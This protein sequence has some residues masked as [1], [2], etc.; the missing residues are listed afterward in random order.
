[1]ISMA[2][3]YFASI[4]WPSG[5]LTLYRKYGFFPPEEAV[6][7]VFPP[8]E[9][10]KL[11]FFRRAEEELA[12]CL[13]T[14]AAEESED[15][16]AVTLFTAAGAGAEEELAT[17]LFAALGEDAAPTVV[18]PVEGDAS[19]FLAPVGAGGK[20]KFSSRTSC[21]P[22]WVSRRGSRNVKAPAD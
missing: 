19:S 5:L 17:T 12:L 15:E 4:T 10:T 13:F 22:V 9:E 3:A 16:A 6:L 11:T 2:F 14:V 8:W 21:C 1:M 18:A 20:K 7:T